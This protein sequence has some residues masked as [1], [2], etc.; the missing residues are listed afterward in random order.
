MGML[1][2]DLKETSRNLSFVSTFFATTSII[3]GLHHSS[4][5]RIALIFYINDPLRGVRAILSKHFV[6]STDFFSRISTLKT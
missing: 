6:S 1:T 4:R 2:L 5:H 3:L